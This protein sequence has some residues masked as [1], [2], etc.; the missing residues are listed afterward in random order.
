MLQENLKVSAC[1]IGGVF[2][3]FSLLNYSSLSFDGVYHELAESPSA[4]E[5]LGEGVQD[6]QKKCFFIRFFVDIV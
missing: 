3:A 2:S 6:D 5:W 1:P 4:S